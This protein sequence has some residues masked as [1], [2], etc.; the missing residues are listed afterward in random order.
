MICEFFD[1]LG[2]EVENF[3]NFVFFRCA[4]VVFFGEFGLACAFG[5]R[6]AAWGAALFGGL[7]VVMTVSALVEG[8]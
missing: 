1:G 8:E 3:F 7:V 2:K 6:A 4:D 5:R